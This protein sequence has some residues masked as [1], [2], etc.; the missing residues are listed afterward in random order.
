MAIL[1][2]IAIIKLQ[3]GR[4]MILNIRNDPNRSGKFAK[5]SNDCRFVVHVT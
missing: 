2:R 1:S 3:Q 5:N 4:F